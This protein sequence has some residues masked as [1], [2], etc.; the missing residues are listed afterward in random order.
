MSR[1]A[2]LWGLLIGLGA[3]FGAQALDHGSPAA[4]LNASALVLIL[5]GTLG[6]TLASTGW[7]TTRQLG[8]WI[9]RAF[10]PPAVDPSATRT[11]LVALARDAR[12][13]GLLR[14][15]DRLAAIPDPFLRDGLSQAVAGLDPTALEAHLQAA[16]DT[17]YR[18]DLT[19]SAF[20]E[21]LGGYSPTMG[22]IGTVL[23]LIAVLANTS[24]L[25]KLAASI[26][27]A[28][29]ATLWGIL[30]ANLLWL[31]LSLRL[32]GLAQAAY[33]ARIV[34]IAG[35]VA[36]ARGDSSRQLERQLAALLDPIPA[37]AAAPSPAPAPAPE[38]SA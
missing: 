20:F 31:P 34:A 5:G 9:R 25:T 4:L 22:I 24:N 32:R 16:N 26:A 30:L 27:T 6:A 19:A 13:Q 17:L 37:E 12:Q 18:R 1:W 10:A 29:T 8:G 14:L 23:G 33:R 3:V 15:E 7:D 21:T 35:I 36:I 2:T 28:F 11:L 38:G